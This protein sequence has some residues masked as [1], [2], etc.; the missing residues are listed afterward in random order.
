MARMKIYRWADPAYKFSEAPEALWL[1]ETSGWLVEED[2][3]T[4]V[5]ASE[6]LTAPDGEVIHRQFTRIPRVLLKC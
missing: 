5:V 6:R 4:I 2:D 3:E 1:C